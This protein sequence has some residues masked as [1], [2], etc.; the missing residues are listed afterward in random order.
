MVTVWPATASVPDRDEL[1]VFGLIDRVTVP[2][3][4]PLAP[5]GIVIHEA[6]D[7][8]VHGQP[9]PAETLRVTLP[10]LPETVDDPPLI[11]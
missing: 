7:D 5:D 6:F 2:F 9:D 8:A 11:E 1:D 3:P 10:P 4:L